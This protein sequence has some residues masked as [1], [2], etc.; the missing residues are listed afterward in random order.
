MQAILPQNFE[1]RASQL[2]RQRDIIPDTVFDPRFGFK[3]FVP[4]IQAPNFAYLSAVYASPPADC[5]NVPDVGFLP[6]NTLAGRFKVKAPN[7]SGYPR[8][9]IM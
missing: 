4:C 3:G 6:M 9:S 8:L 1:R 7:S 2:Y 5:L